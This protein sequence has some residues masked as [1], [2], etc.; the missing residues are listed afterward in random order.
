MELVSKDLVI[1]PKK[2]QNKSTAYMLV[3]ISQDIYHAFFD[4]TQPEYPE[5]LIAKT[6]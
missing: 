1:K 4:Q 6:Q 2:Y 5:W 3:Y